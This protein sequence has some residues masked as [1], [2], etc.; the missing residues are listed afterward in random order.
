MYVIFFELD[1]YFIY[2]N[3]EFFDGLKN[4]TIKLILRYRVFIKY[5]GFFSEVLKIFR[6]LAFLCFPSVSVCVQTT[7]RYKTSAAEELAEFRKITKF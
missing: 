2:K 5:R 3:L 7:G 4:Q 6:T 1:E